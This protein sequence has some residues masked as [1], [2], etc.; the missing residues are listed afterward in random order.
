MVQGSGDAVTLTPVA[1]EILLAL[2]DSDQHGYAILRSVQDR[3]GRG[4][5]RHAGTLYR[6][7]ARLVD[8][9]LI[10]ELDDAPDASADARRR[11]YRV[12][13]DGRLAATEE[14]RRLDRQLGAARDLG[15]L[16]PA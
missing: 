11:Y 6:A 13:P 2:L 15:L 16:G 5:S 10:E 14:A 9:G 7:L 3:S 1:F 8:A 12:T 4:S